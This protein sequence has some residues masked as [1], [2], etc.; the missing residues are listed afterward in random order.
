M[1]RPKL[2]LVL[3]AALVVSA[4]AAGFAVAGMG[5]GNDKTFQYAIGLWGNMP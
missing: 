1:S 3:F 4:T 2:V 5:N